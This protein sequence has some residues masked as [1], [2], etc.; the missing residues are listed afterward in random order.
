[1]IKSAAREPTI[2]DDSPTRHRAADV[3]FLRTPGEF[4]RHVQ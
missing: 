4:P 1:M 3:S 2:H